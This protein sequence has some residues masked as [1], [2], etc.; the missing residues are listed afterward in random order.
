MNDA[1]DQIRGLIWDGAINV[2]VNAKHSLLLN[3]VSYKESVF[4]LR[5]PRDTYLVL[6]LPA[7]LDYLRNS[8]RTNTD[9]NDDGGTYW[10]EFENVSLYWNYPMG[11][12]YDSMLALNPPGR[13]SKDT[14]NSINVWKI[15]LA[16]GSI[17]PNGLIPLIGGTEQIKSYWMHQ[18]KQSC[19]ILNGSAKQVMSLSMQDSQKFWESILTRDRT[20]F[21][22]VS[23][24]IVPKRPKYIPIIFHQTLPEIKRVQPSATEYK[25]D[26]S[27]Q[28]LEDLARS[29][30]PEFF[31]DNQ[32][33]IKAVSNGIEVPLESNVLELYRRLMSFDGFLHI[34]ICL[35]SNDE[36][37]E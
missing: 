15:E 17:P 29:Q 20:T 25:K 35:V 26:G 33:L 5:I 34:S 8:L 2:Q 7:I 27:P 18:W 4:N 10:F 13:I 21:E 6:Y 14:G 37:L 11:V 9:N 22:S 36:Y 28:I 3:E 31:Q 12:L 23:S 19:H 24:K 30:F 32:V 16:Y 1:M